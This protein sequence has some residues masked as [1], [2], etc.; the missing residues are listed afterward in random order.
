M[1]PTLHIA[2]KSD[3]VEIASLVNRAYRPAST[4][5]GWTHEARLVAGYR[6]CPEQVEELLNGDSTVLV[7]LQEEHIVSCVNV[8]VK[9]SVAYIGM[10][11]T[12]PRLQASG[13]GKTMMAHAE[14]FA[15]EVFGVSKF[16]M[17]VLSARS[18]LIAFYERR[19]YVRTGEM[20]DYPV[21]ENVGQPLVRDLAVETLLKH[22]LALKR[23]QPE[24]TRIDW[25]EQ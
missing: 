17:S 13:L 1:L 19:G 2:K 24:I 12:E 8:L 25:K 6:I 23:M 22:A 11:A 3:S 15:M 16:K 20:Q 7:L 10:L 5:F 9:D 21:S 14:S 18:E 4:D